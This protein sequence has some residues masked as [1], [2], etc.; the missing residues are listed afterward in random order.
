MQ[1]KTPRPPEEAQYKALTKVADKTKF[2]EAWAREK[3]KEPCSMLGVSWLG[4]W[5]VVGGGW[6]AGGRWPVVRG[7]LGGGGDPWLMYSSLTDCLM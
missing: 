1:Y 5:W 3:L 2:R 7:V 6:R 4:W